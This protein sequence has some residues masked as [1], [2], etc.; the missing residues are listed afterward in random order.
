VRAE[1]IAMGDAAKAQAMSAAEVTIRTL[2]AAPA[3]QPE[4][5]VA[6]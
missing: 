6:A 4:E 2:S 3:R 5:A 1:G